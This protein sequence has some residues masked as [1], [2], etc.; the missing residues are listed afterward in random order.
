M[1]AYPPPISV[2]LVVLCQALCN[3]SSAALPRVLKADAF[4]H[5]VDQFNRD[6]NELYVQHIPNAAAWE[7]LKSNIPLLDCPDKEIEQIYYFRWWT[8]RKAIKQTPD[9]FIITEFLPNVGWAG[10]YNSIDCAAGHHFREGRW[11]H[12]PKY[13]DDYSRFWFRR[14]GSPRSYSFW[15]ADSLWSRFLVTGDDRLVKELLPDLIANYEAWEQTHRDANGLFW[16]IDDRDGMEVSIGGSGYRATINTY[17]YGDALAIAADCRSVSGKNDIAAQFRAKA[18]E[19]GRL[20]QEKLWDPA[21]QFFKVLPRGRG[22]SSGRRSRVARLHAMVLQPARSRQ[23]GR[24][25]T[26][27]GPARLLCPLRADNRRA[28]ASQIRGLLP[29][30]RVP[31]ERAELAVLDGHHVD[32]HGQLL[33]R[34]PARCGQRAAITSIC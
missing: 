34:L 22:A 17:M 3:E 19:I 30:P 11:L 10:K 1:L 13:L 2:I 4:Q 29:G 15:A 26:D 32:G 25:E 6:D 24:L 23:I 18:A 9:G 12:D 16:Q 27:H 5:Y 33:E 20:T 31:V 8:F 7:F 28:A 14:G 21:A